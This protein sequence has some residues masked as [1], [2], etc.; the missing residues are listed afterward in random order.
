MLLAVLFVAACSHKGDYSERIAVDAVAEEVQMAADQSTRADISVN[1]EN[2]T[3]PTADK[4]I[5]RE[6]RMGI[7]V[8][9]IARA[10]TNVTALVS[11]YN[12]YYSRDNYHD[13]RSELS[14]DLVIRLPNRNFEAFISE[15]E[16]DD[17]GKLLY[18][19]INARD[20]TEEYLDVETRLGNKKTYLARYR[21]LVKRAN[22]IK[23][24]LE[25]EEQIRVLEEEIESAE[26]RL[27]YLGDQVSYSTLYLRLSEEI[28]YTPVD[29][30]SAWSRFKGSLA[31]GWSIVVE[32]FHVL[33][34]IWP[35]LLIGAA[36]LL[37]LLRRRK[38]GRK[39]K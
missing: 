18:K 8:G 35:L 38:H 20:V 15:L 7:R 24:I 5:I 16:S 12:G 2:I 17:N 11:K 31:T 6:G 23:E 34:K 14:Y 19:E 33:V 1:E 9:D 22:T 13:S 4:K 30:D 37:L 36:L 25:V 21:E 39:D 26:G 27:R 3:S 32:L 28:E 10:K 29:E